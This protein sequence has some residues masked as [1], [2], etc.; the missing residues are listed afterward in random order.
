MGCA[1]SYSRAVELIGVANCL[2]A[3]TVIFSTRAEHM[4]SCLPTI[5]KFSQKLAF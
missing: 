1:A 2:I 3:D 5:V 4:K